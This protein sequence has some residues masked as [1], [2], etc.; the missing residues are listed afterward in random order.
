[1]PLLAAVY[2][3]QLNVIVKCSF[4]VAINDS[5]MSLGQSLVREDFS[6]PNSYWFS[7][8]MQD[9]N[10]ENDQYVIVGET[11]RFN[12]SKTSFGPVKLLFRWIMH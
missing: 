11:F 4:L 2:M 5:T 12:V 1:M 10:K 8:K 6:C 7:D 3:L 9:I